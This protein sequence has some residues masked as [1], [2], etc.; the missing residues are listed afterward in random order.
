MSTV[1]DIRIRHPEMYIEDRGIDR[2]KCRRVVPMEVLNLSMSRT[3]TASMKAALLI[4]GY[5]DCYHFFNI[6]ENIQD[7][8]MWV[9]AY[10]AK[11]Q[12]KGKFGRA[13]FDKILGHCRAVC[14][15]PCN[16]F[17]PELIEAYP[18]AKVLLVE[19]DIESW[20]K[21]WNVVLD[22]IFDK[23]FHVAEW[24]DP[25]WMGR[26]AALVRIWM[27]ED[28]ESPTMPEAQKVSRDKY[29]A[30]YAEIRRVTPKERL[31]EYELGSGW[32]PL[33]KFLGKPVPDVPFPRINEASAY[34]EKMAVLG[35]KV[36]IR[37]LRNLAGVLVVG[38]AI[39]FGVSRYLL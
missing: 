3:G 23:T 9:E 37:S 2:H 28:L 24:F 36:I 33:C 30:H 14:D 38:G 13:E 4:L 7:C 22:G 21:S 31:L 29:R 35:R 18:E 20:Y 19:R 12:G 8:D 25:A 17:G 10:Q 27:N 15:A 5:N 1:E 32:E 16:S 11:F 26:L 6:Y 39:A 34:R